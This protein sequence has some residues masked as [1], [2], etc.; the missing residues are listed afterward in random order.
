MGDFSPR[1]YSSSTLVFST[2]MNATFTPCSGRFRTSATFASQLCVVCDGRVE[3]GNG[4]SHVIQ[5]SE[6][7]M[8]HLFLLMPWSRSSTELAASRTFVPGP[9]TAATP[10]SMR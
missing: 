5:S 2:S 8:P 4:D 7:E 3:I 1:G 6:H 10:F 9:K